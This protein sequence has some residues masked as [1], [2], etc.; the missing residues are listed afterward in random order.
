VHCVNIFLLGQLA[1]PGA[2]P[3]AWYLDLWC[4]TALPG[5]L[6]RQPAHSIQKYKLVK[7]HTAL[8]NDGV[9]SALNIWQD[10]LSTEHPGFGHLWQQAD[11][12][13]VDIVI[14]CA[15]NA[16]AV[17]DEAQDGQNSTLL[18]QFPGHSTILSSSPYFKAQASVK[19]LMWRDKVG[20]EQ[21]C[22]VLVL[23]GLL[24]YSNDQDDIFK[25]IQ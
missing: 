5:I 9:A 13:H 21:L 25:C 12:S 10:T 20:P 6:E 24:I 14:A 17:G 16:A 2:N 11:L 23:L 7:H 1:S 3:R 15:K 8:H 22:P 19:L 4:S 18:Q